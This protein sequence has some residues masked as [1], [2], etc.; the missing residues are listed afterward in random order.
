MGA[1]AVRP[2]TTDTTD[3]T[4]SSGP[5]HTPHATRHTPHASM[6]GHASPAA[7]RPR[8]ARASGRTFPP[9][10]RDLLSRSEADPAPGV[11]WFEGLIDAARARAICDSRSSDESEAA[12]LG[13]A[14]C[15]RGECELPVT[16]IL[17]RTIDGSVFAQRVR[18]VRTNYDY[19]DDDD[20]D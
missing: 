20:N 17:A 15:V 6:R 5:R 19:E 11:D 7:P 12:L 8:P 10:P 18:R 14:G 2:S 9:T 16:V 4:H 1:E 3:T 13:D